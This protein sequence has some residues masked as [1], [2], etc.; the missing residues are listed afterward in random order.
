MHIN[1]SASFSGSTTEP[2]SGSAEH[3]DSSPVGA[4]FAQMDQVLN[5]GKEQEETAQAE[6]SDEQ[7]SSA[8]GADSLALILNSVLSAGSSQTQE[9]AVKSPSDQEDVIPVRGLKEDVQ[10]A[11]RVALRKDAFITD[12]PIA[13]APEVLKGVTAA[14]TI[15][16][17]VPASSETEPDSSPE[18]TQH[19]RNALP[20]DPGLE[21]RSVKAQDGRVLAQPVSADTAALNRTESALESH[22]V[23]AGSESS[24]VAERV[25]SADKPQSYENTV[26]RGKSQE[27]GAPAKSQYYVQLEHTGTANSEAEQDSQQSDSTPKIVLTNRTD[28]SQ[29]CGEVNTAGGERLE[30]LS[31]LTAVQPRPAFADAPSVTSKPMVASQQPGEFV[32]QLAERIRFQLQ[33]GKGE[34]RIQLKPDSLGRLEIRAESSLNGVV[35]RIFAESNAVKNYLESNLHLLQQT[36]QEQ[37]LK[38]DRI[39]VSV[40]DGFGSPSSAGYTLESGNTGPGYQGRGTG[41][42][43]A[44]ADFPPASPQEEL[45]VDAATWVSLNPNVRFHTIA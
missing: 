35:A 6:K 7:I 45:P 8:A 31:P 32:L 23:V 30:V 13:A 5:S 29:V 28:R 34:I 14:S 21:H 25:R 40:Q 3:A 12:T 27:T 9:A 10:P 38:I 15:P 16:A 26:L 42:I 43:P 41:R 44:P 4:F 36:L 17:G 19:P 33:D 37:G 1:L 39:Q 2:A 24:E 18:E 22:P 11:G 20:S